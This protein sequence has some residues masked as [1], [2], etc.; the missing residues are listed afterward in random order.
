[1]SFADAISVVM[2]EKRLRPVDIAVGS[3]TKQYISK[4]LAGKISNPTWEKA[5]SICDALDVSANELRSIELAMDSEKGSAHQI[6]GEVRSIP[7]LEVFSLPSSSADLVTVSK[8]EIPA[9]TTRGERDAAF[10]L[11]L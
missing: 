9:L 2:E 6:E 3:V 5:W 7:A 11:S 4:L 10:K 1:M 8:A